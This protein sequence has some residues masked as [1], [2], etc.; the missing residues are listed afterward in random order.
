[1]KTFK[2]MSEFRETYF[3]KSVYVEFQLSGKDAERYMEG[4]AITVTIQR[5][6]E[7][8]GTAFSRTKP[9]KATRG[10]EKVEPRKIGL[11]I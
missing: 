6:I 10:G 7:G 3:P 2:N 11:L 1:M 5:P 8:E 4:E 9:H